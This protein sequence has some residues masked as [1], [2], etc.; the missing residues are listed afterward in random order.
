LL[1]GFKNMKPTIE[2]IIAAVVIIVTIIALSIKVVPSGTVGVV[3]TFGVVQS[4]PRQPGL[5]FLIPL[6][7]TV[8]EISIQT[9]A[10]P[11]EFTVQTRDSQQIKVTA[12]ATYAINPP[13]APA[14]V[15]NIGRTEDAVR[16]VV[17]QPVLI[18]SVKRVVTAYAMQEVIENQARI[19][20]EIREDIIKELDK[21]G[22]VNFRDFAVTGFV[23]DIEVQKSIEQKQIAIQERQRKL[24]ELETAQIEAQRLKTLDAVLSDRI[25]LKQAIDKWDGSSMIPP[26]AGGGNMNLLLSPKK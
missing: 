8:Q 1:K 9:K 16:N 15:A 11:E 19:S 2:R 4:P 13:N 14:I 25:L 23:L 21:Q 17:I 5:N 26:M 18:S 3:S 12:T 24:T 20:G 22:Y 6:V 7:Q 10:I